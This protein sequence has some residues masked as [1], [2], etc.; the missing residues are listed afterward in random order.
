[1]P[2]IL[3]LEQPI[4]QL[5]CAATGAVGWE[6]LGQSADRRLRRSGVVFGGV[7]SGAVDLPKSRNT[8]R[9][10]Q[11]DRTGLALG[12]LPLAPRANARAGGNSVPERPHLRWQEQPAHRP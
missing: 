12:A 8:N 11:V 6:Q 5:P 10:H 9:D 7:S 1:M 4:R 2:E 3:E